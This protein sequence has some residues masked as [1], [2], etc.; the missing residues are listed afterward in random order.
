[1]DVT[2]NPLAL[3]IAV[4]GLIIVALIG[5]PRI[6]QESDRD[7][8]AVF[9][10]IGVTLGAGAIVWIGFFVWKANRRRRILSALLSAAMSAHGDTQVVCDYFPDI[11]VC[12]SEKWI[13]CAREREVDVQP[14]EQMVWSYAEYFI[15]RF[16]YQLVI[17]NRDACANVMP[18]R[19]RYLK[20]ALERLQHCAPW[21]PVGY[22]QTMKESWNAD[23]R[24]FLALV[25]SC[26]Q[27]RRRFDLPWAGRGAARVVGLPRRTNMI[28]DIENKRQARELQKLTE[29]WDREAE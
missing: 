28:Q 26:R 5:D 9:F 16:H 14:L 20:A 4:L 1:M 24:E 10:L 18:I 11:P 15:Q 8:F 6:A 17:W 7:I 25:A 3:A 23:H 29:R 2:G 13:Y 27:S 19:K 12:V 22:S 21:L